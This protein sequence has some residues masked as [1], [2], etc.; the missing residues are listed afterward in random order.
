MTLKSSFEQLVIFWTYTA[1]G[2]VK[3]DFQ[4]HW[5]VLSGEFSNLTLHSLNVFKCTV[6]F[7]KVLH[8]NLNEMLN[9]NQTSVYGLF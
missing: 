8:F 7:H 1:N 2:F 6:G 9:F 3:T 5:T 4:C